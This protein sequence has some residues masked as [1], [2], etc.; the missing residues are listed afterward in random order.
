MTGAVT[1]TGAC[2]DLGTPDAFLPL[3]L[4]CFAG[5]A[6]L[7]PRSSEAYRRYYSKADIIYRTPVVEKGLIA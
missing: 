3:F 4:P 1:L 2:S 7:S 5:F 6:I